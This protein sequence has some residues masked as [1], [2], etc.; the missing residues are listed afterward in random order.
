MTRG[1]RSA[2]FLEPPYRAR[3][4]GGAGR[5]RD[6]VLLASVHRCWPRGW[7][8]GLGVLGAGR[9]GGQVQAALRLSRRPAPT[10]MALG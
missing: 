9:G 1:G 2:A 6:L 3:P 4:C 8:G 5:T 10:A 7:V